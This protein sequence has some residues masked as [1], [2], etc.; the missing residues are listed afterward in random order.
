MSCPPTINFVA[1]FACEVNAIEKNFMAHIVIV[2]HQFD[3]FINGT[4]LLR[5]LLDHWIQAGHSI[6]IAKGLGDWPAGDIAILHV[7]LTVVPDAYAEACKKYPVVLNGAALDIRKKVVS[8][9]LVA[10]DDGWS[11]PVIVKTDLNCGGLQELR[12]R[13]ILQGRAM[14]YPPEEIAYASGPYPI[15]N[16]V[17]L[18]PEQVWNIPGLVVERFLPEQDER[19]FWMRA[20][21]FL[22]DRERCTRILSSDPIVKGRNILARESVAV[23]D[24]MRAERERLGFDYGKFDFVIHDGKPIL[25]D[26]NKTP[27]AP[28]ANPDLAAL[29]AI[30]AQG[31][32]TLLRNS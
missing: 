4:Y 25:L 19:G 13:Q 27:G 8:R 7:D 31:I 11:G 32:D 16:S 14:E 10:L 1:H 24:E 18:V 9:Q 17:A 21:V 23:P 12:V 6:T 5:Q 20:W 15:L 3:G 29:N 28:P 30:L 2:T 26:A 22:G